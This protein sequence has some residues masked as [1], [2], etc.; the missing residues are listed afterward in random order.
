MKNCNYVAGQWVAGE[1][2]IK[3]INPSD[4][5]DVIDEYTNATSQQLNDAVES[6]QLAQKK[7]EHVGI[8]KRA[9]ILHNIGSELIKQSKEI[10]TLLSREE[11]KTLPEG[12]GEVVR[13]GQ[14]F[15][16]YAAS[17]LRQFGENIASTRDG[18]SVEMTREPVGVCG[19]I[20]PWNFPI[21][22][23]AWK[24]APAIAFGNAIVLKPASQT[25][26]SAIALTKIISEQ[27]DIPESVVNLVLRGG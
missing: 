27:K 20:S 1:G 21:A 18:V 6:A 3:N 12:I 4:T 22:I 7:W 8:E 5:N 17:A 2:S 26:A 13:S 25:P 24:S 14:Q 23:A 9:N 15:Q 16:Y 10:G 19:I 11:G